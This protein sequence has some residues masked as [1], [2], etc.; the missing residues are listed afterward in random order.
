M[1][2]S[3]GLSAGTNTVTFADNVTPT[4]VMNDAMAD[5]VTLFRDYEN[6]GAN[7][8]YKAFEARINYGSSFYRRSAGA[9]V[10]EF[11]N[12]AVDGSGGF[13]NGAYLFPFK[14][15]MEESGKPTLKYL[16]RQEQADYDNFAHHVCNTP[17]DVIVG[18]ADLI[19]R[20]AKAGTPAAKLLDEF[21]HNVD[22]HGTAILDFL[23]YPHKQARRFGTGIIIMDRPSFENRSE[24]DNKNPQ[25]RPWV[26]AVPTQN[27]VHWEFGEDGELAGIVVLVPQLIDLGDGKG[28]QNVTDVRVWTRSQ[29]AVFRR[30]SDTRHDGTTGVQESPGETFELIDSGDH[31][32]GEVPVVAI[33]NDTPE[34]GHL[35]AHTEMLD[36]ARIAQTVYNIDSEAREIERK[37]ALFLAIPVKNTDSFSEKKAIISTENALLFDGEAG[38]PQWIS[39]DL[40]ILEN[41]TT[42]REAKKLDAYKMAGL[43]AIA[44][45]TD[46][47]S[48]AS[49]YHAEVEFQKTERRIARHASMLEAA[50]KRLARLYLK[51]YGIDSDQEAD[52]F[53]IT[54][55][56]D[57]GVRDMEALVLRTKE[58]LGLNLGEKWDQR[59]L[60]KLAKAQF[61]R[62][63]D[64]EIAE[65]V[66]DAVTERSAAKKQQ[67]ELERVKSMAAVLTRPQPGPGAAAEGKGPQPK[68][69]QKAPPAKA[70][71]PDPKKPEKKKVAA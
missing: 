9:N 27:V 32:L 12:D 47:V 33:Y 54:Y 8:E 28:R 41:L 15:E 16:K 3:A 40:G 35:L 59:T 22:L 60:E 48:T 56:R 43:G 17:W 14:L 7:P 51:F 52:L 23:E 19:E 31:K 57:Y 50:E 36:V 24:A 26:Y 29:W 44:A 55:P 65:M 2:L 70:E 6:N 37:C 34:P 67:Q 25:N 11:I 5:V 66:E 42:R 62:M 63:S 45:T 4:V 71:K 53:S 61:P 39:P 20:K 46:T 58:I 68:P 64:E 18:S 38:A 21:W 49:G 30:T 10:W 13:A 69:G 1:T